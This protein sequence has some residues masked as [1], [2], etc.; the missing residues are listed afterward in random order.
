MSNMF[1]FNYDLKGIQNNPLFIESEKEERKNILSK[2][3]KIHSCTYI[4]GKD[5]V[6]I[7]VT[8]P[9]TKEEEDCYIKE[10]GISKDLSYNIELYNKCKSHG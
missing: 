10:L 1:K 6:L 8:E 7:L 2:L 4:Q 5:Y 3:P 9:L